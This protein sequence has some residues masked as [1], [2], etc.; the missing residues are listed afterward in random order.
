M[1]RLLRW[2]ATLV[3]VAALTFIG[4]RAASYV[5]ARTSNVGQLDSTNTL[6]IPPLLA[7]RDQNGRK[8]FE[9]TLETGSAQFMP[10]KPA[11][12]WGVNGPYL[13]P[14]LRA[15]RGD[16]VAVRVHNELPEA[17]TLHWHG[18]H[19]GGAADGGPHQVIAPGA[20]WEPSWRIDQPAA[21]LWYHPHPHGATADHVYRGVAGLFI[22]DEPESTALALPHQ[23]GINDIPLIIQDKRLHADGSLDFSERS[24]SPTGRLGDTILINGTYNPHVSVRDARVRFRLLNASNARIYNLGFADERPFDLIATDAGLLERPHLLHRLQLSPG[25]RAEIVVAFAPGE[26]I[27]LRS[28]PP[29]LGT[30]FFERRFSGGDDSFDLLQIRAATHPDPAPPVAQRLAAP[31]PLNQTNAT[32]T[33]RFEL[34]ED[35][36][37]NHQRMD[38]TR[39]DAVVPVGTPEIWEVHNGGG[40]PHNFHVHGGSFRVVQY[41]DGPL[42]AQLDGPKDTV[43]VRPGTVVRFLV[44]FDHTADPETPFMFHCHILQHEDHGMMGQFVVTEQAPPRIA[45]VSAPAS[46]ASGMLPGGHGSATV[47]RS[48]AGAMTGGTETAGASE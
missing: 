10:G 29:D 8:A 18:M 45:A 30:N 4:A 36:T 46:A 22:V 5:N 11:E 40:S 41:G 44:R 21:T 43:Y 15:S 25:E 23:Y 28:F 14:T 20:T 17:T 34:A 37:I 39:I 31:E 6:A 9:L 12:T 33:R 19:L 38:M 16:T 42:P 24:F 26:S 1:K 27:V 7:P 3:A 2:S 48:E 32:R 35:E 47:T 13:G